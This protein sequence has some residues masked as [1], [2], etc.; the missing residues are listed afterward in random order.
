M[1]N[2]A[3][4]GLSVAAPGCFGLACSSFVDQHNCGS[5][6]GYLDLSLQTHT[7]PIRLS[8]QKSPSCGVSASSSAVNDVRVEGDSL[9]CVCVLQIVSLMKVPAVT[10]DDDLFKKALFAKYV[11]ALPHALD[12]WKDTG[13]ALVGNLLSGI[14][15]VMQQSTALHQNLFRYTSSSSSPSST[16]FSSSSPR[17]SAVFCMISHPNSSLGLQ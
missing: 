1:V 9:T 17:P 13:L 8:P 10:E 16:W 4:T 15:K 2:Q 5:V 7:H 14:Q 3:A 11:E 6:C 12:S